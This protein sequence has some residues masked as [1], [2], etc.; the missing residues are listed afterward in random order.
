M[1]YGVYDVRCNEGLMYLA[2][3]TDTSELACD[4]V[5]RWW[6]RLGRGQ[7]WG[8][9]RLLL[10]CDCGGSNGNRQHRFKE[11]LCYLARDLRLDI[12]VAH[13]P[14]ARRVELLHSL[15]SIGVPLRRDDAFGDGMVFS[16]HIFRAGPLTG[17]GICR[18][19]HGR[20]ES[21]HCEGRDEALHGGLASGPC[22]SPWWT[23]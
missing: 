2:R 15:I 17:C 16:H 7:H 3:G 23:G 10:L 9:P 6:Q 8:A 5:R 13:Y 12:Q 21:E 4:A 18:H 14:P 1:P 20:N 22:D 19:S 11:E